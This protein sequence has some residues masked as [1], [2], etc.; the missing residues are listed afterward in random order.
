VFH[1]IVT[2][3]TDELV[4]STQ[5]QTARYGLVYRQIEHKSLRTLC[6]DIKKTSLPAKYSKLAPAGG[7]GPDLIS[8][9][10]A[11]LD[12]QEKRHLADYDPLFRVGIS[13]AALA[14]A[15]SRTALVRFRNAPSE[16]RKV[17]LSLLVFSPR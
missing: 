15:T 14:I 13:D 7:F 1:A 8:V 10:T 2:D 12:L 17:F 5:R 9:A 11:V 4:G 3:A 6:E 16:P